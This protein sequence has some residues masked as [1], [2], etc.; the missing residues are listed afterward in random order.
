MKLEATALWR[1]WQVLTVGQGVSSKCDR[2]VDIVD[3]N[4]IVT[5]SANWPFQ[6]GI[7]SEWLLTSE[8][9]RK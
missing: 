9:H 5:V 7:H 8:Y 1:S 2:Q 4:P 3:V 6:P